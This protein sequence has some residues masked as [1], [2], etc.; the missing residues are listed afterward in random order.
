VVGTL[1]EC[2]DVLRLRDAVGV[3]LSHA[4]HFFPATVSGR[5]T[6]IVSRPTRGTKRRFTASC[7]IKRT[8]QRAAPGGGALQAIATMRCFSAGASTSVAPG[9]G[10]SYKAR[11]RPPVR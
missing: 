5:G 3:Q 7:A 2:Q 1:V 11:V 8:V 6:R 9:R 10:R 4:P